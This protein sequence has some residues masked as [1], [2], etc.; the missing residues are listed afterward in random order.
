MK[1]FSIICLAMLVFSTSFSA[2][3]KVLYNKCK[4]CHGVDGKY[5]PFE[6][7]RGVLAGRNKAEIET[8]IK[9][10]RDGNNSD[11]KI[12]KIMQ[13]VLKKFSEED[14]QSISKYIGN[15]KKSNNLKRIILL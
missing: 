5:I 2:E 4:G 9:I 14:I 10:I 12:S 1:I 15:F 3:G 6:R 7:E 8:L 11:D 13:H